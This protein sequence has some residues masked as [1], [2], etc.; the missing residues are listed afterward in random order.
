MGDAPE[1]ADSHPH[2]ART[3]AFRSDRTVVSFPHAGRY[4]LWAQFRVAGQVEGRACSCCV[5]TRSTCASQIAHPEVAP[6]GAIHISVTAAG[7]EPA[8]VEVPKD[9]PV[10]LWFTRTGEPNCGSQVVIPSLNLKR[11]LPLDGSVLVEL[12]AQ[13]SGEI[14]F[15]CG[16][17]MLRG[18]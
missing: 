3:R 15:T 13:P 9:T 16:M 11:D 17:N 10:K 2:G 14:R 12:P 18:M 8:R 6:A 1:T 5:W 4:K 7:Y